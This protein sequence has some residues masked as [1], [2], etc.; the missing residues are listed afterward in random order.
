M[1]RLLDVDA[2]LK[3][4]VPDFVRHGD[5][6]L[7]SG[8]D[9]GGTYQHVWFEEDVSADEVSI[10]ADVYLLTKARAM[11]LKAAPAVAGTGIAAVPS[12]AAAVVTRAPSTAAEPAAA[13]AAVA[14][15]AILRL[16]GDV[17]FESWN[18]IGTKL[19]SKLKAAGTLSVS[20]DAKVSLDA[21]Q[22]EAL[23]KELKAALQELG[24]ED[25]LRMD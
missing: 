4:K 8:A 24:L 14:G 25:R 17:P 23:R 1:E 3:A 15:P 21:R 19:L 5:F 18:R 7:A 12:G 13:P 6:G 2:Y 11:A 22:A 9:P 10:D 16:V 20:L